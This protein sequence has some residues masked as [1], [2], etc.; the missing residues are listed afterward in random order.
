MRAAT[1]TPVSSV[2]ERILAEAQSVWEPRLEQ[3]LLRCQ[4]LEAT[5]AAE[6]ARHRRY[7]SLGAARARGDADTIASLR[8]WV[9]ELEDRLGVA[10]AKVVS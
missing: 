4:A 5:L 7:V 6:R 9:L 3:A 2:I 1:S 8:S 10:R